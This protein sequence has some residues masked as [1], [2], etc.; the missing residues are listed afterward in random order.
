MKLL[1]SYVT[2]LMKKFEIPVYELDAFIPPR[3]SDLFNI[4]NYKQLLYR[5]LVRNKNN[6]FN[7]N[8]QATIK[9][10]GSCLIDMARRISLHTF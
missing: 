2:R 3:A 5:C 6:E 9:T 4:V 10:H 8:K 7:F 1:E